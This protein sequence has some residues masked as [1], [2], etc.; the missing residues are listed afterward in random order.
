MRGFF[1]FDIHT[2]SNLLQ[3]IINTTCDV[4]RLLG[5]E[6]AKRGVKAYVRIQQP[7][8]EGSKKGGHDESDDLKPAGVLGTW[9]HE[10]LRI[11]GAIDGSVSLQSYLSI[12]LILR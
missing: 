8:Y 12:Q 11:L 3:I 9:W 10:A 4:T 6:A 5:L 7:F 1:F 2:E